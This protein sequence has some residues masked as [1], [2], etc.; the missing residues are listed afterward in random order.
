ML[1]KV[2]SE[3]RRLRLLLTD[4]PPQEDYPVQGIRNVSGADLHSPN[5]AMT[6]SIKLRI[7]HLTREPNVRKGSNADLPLAAW[8]RQFRAVNQCPLLAQSHPT[9]FSESFC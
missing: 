9:S 4:C 6:S 2:L 8:Q 5:R 7:R 1:T 3:T